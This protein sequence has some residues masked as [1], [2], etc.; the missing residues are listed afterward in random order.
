MLGSHESSGYPD[1]TISRFKLLS[2]RSLAARSG[3]VLAT[4]TLALLAMVVHRPEIAATVGGKSLAFM[5][6]F[7]LP[8]LALLGGASRHYEQA[9]TTAFCLSCHAIQPYRESLHIDDARFLPAAHYQNRRIPIDR[10]CYACHGA[11]RCSGTSTTRFAVCGTCGTPYGGLPPTPSSCI[12]PM[13][14][15]PVWHTMPRGGPTKSRQP[16]SRF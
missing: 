11:T 10:A 16:T 13:R 3:S 9:Q 12:N 4:A 2:D 1:P 15:E 14:T 5:A 7:A 8:G 6:L